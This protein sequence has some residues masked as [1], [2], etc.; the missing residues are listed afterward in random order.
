MLLL[1]S[2]TGT[3]EGVKPWDRGGDKTPF[4]STRLLE[5]AY[6]EVLRWSEDHRG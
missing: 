2:L 5:I 6:R 1:I 4:D 3:V